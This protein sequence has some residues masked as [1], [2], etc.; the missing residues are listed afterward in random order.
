MAHPRYEKAYHAHLWPPLANNHF[1][2]AEMGSSSEHI[3]NDY[4]CLRL[5]FHL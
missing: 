1:R 4:N 2:S 3:I 5:W